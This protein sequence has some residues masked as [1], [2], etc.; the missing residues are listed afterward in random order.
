MEWLWWVGGAVVVLFAIDRV[1]TA[2]EDRG[3]L[4]WR[5]PRPRAGRGSSAAGGT[6]GG[7]IEAFQPNHQYLV[8][9]Q[10]RQRSDIQQNE[11]GAPP[12]GIDLDTGVAYLRPRRTSTDA[13]SED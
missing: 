1:F 12:Q 4:F 8:A 11:D 9:E 6:L 7:L 5:K 13:A 3:H 10:E 2:L